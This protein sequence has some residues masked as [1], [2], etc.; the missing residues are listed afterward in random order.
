MVG[1]VRA[2]VRRRQNLPAGVQ[3]VGPKPQ[4]AQRP[5]ARDLLRSLDGLDL[6]ALKLQR[7]PAL[8]SSLREKRPNRIFWMPVN[9]LAHPRD[10]GEQRISL[11]KSLRAVLGR[12]QELRG[13]GFRQLG[14][15]EAVSFT[16]PLHDVARRRALLANAGKQD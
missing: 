7:I 10:V 8:L 2:P 14:D 9:L 12:Q 13:I 1:S 11:R 5:V 3:S 16:L 6:E 4:D 15:A